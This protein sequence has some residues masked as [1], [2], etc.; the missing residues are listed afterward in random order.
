MTPALQKRRLQLGSAL[1][2]APRPDRGHPTAEELSI[3]RFSMEELSMEELS[4][5]ERSMEELS[6][7]KMFT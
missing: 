1:A 2:P 4:M 5:E 3:E 7:E 6:M